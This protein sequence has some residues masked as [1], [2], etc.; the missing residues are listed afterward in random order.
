MTEMIDDQEVKEYV[1]KILLHEMFKDGRIDNEEKQM[2]LTL[3]PVVGLAQSKIVELFNST[4][5][6]FSGQVNTA[7]EGTANFIQ[8]FDQVR[9]RLVEQYSPEQTDKYLETL[10][11]G[12]NRQ[13]E[14]YESL[15]VGF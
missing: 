4:R 11:E 5:T 6:E 9:K 14:F 2:L 3:G 13:S 15:S 8:L 7:S 1:V 12:L 10:A